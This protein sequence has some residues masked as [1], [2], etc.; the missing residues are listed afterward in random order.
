MEYDYGRSGHGS[1]GYEMGRPMYHSRQGSNV[2]GSY[3]RVGQSAGDA[4]MN[5]G[6]PQAPLLSVPSFPCSTK[7]AEQGGAPELISVRV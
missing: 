3:P 7:S 4:L 5:R 2:Q 1:G 6:P